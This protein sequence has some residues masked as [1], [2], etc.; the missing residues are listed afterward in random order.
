M[1]PTYSEGDWLLFKA[2]NQVGNDQARRLV[3]KVVVIERE[4][5]PGILYL[6]RLMFMDSLGCWVE[7]D[8]KTGSTD[9]RQ[10]G[11]ISAEEI[12]GLVLFRY[13]RNKS[14]E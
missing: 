14:S 10:W 8:N 4:K 1:H 6:K 11:A 13:K 9:S 7:G 2:L 12:I 3:G 5:Y